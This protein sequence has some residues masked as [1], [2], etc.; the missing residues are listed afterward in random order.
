[1][2]PGRARFSNRIRVG[3]ETAR[4]ASPRHER[5]SKGEPEVCHARQLG[6]QIS[7]SDL[8]R[9]RR[10]GFK[11]GDSSAARALLAALRHAP[12]HPWRPHRRWD[13]GS[14][15]P[16]PRPG[17]GARAAP[18]RRRARSLGFSAGVSSRRRRRASAAPARSCASSRAPCSTTR[19]CPGT[20]MW[21]PPTSPRLPRV[22]PT[23]RPRPA[24]PSPS[25]PRAFWTPCARSTRTRCTTSA[26]WTYPPSASRSAPATCTTRAPRW[27]SPRT[28]RRWRASSTWP[29]AVASSAGFARLCGSAQDARGGA[30]RVLHHRAAQTRASALGVAGRVPPAHARHG[31][32]RA[33]RHP[34]L[35]DGA[36]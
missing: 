1:M 36:P 7:S 27:P 11:D 18:V 31:R 30:R 33:E 15:R 17:P 32:A 13:A 23:T 10:R 19:A 28:P 26:W 12:W 14:P 20:P 4:P 3:P 34:Q 9:T 8:S 6:W 5:R 16:R 2:F 29:C 21:T 24:R 25:S 22:C 35:P